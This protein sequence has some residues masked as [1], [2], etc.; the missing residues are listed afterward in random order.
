MEDLQR[1]K[2]MYMCSHIPHSPQHLRSDQVSEHFD[3]NWIGIE[4]DVRQESKSEK[5]GT[6]MEWR[7]TDRWVFLTSW[8]SYLDWHT[9]ILLIITIAHSFFSIR[10]ELPLFQGLTFQ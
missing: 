9:L 4:F 2:D 5:V 6:V 3:V 7:S 1:D 10:V 8:T